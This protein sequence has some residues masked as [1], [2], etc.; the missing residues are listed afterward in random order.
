MLTLFPPPFPANKEPR[1]R[2]DPCLFGTNYL[3]ILTIDSYSLVRLQE[4]REKKI[5]SQW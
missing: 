2:T 5:S 4:T 1:E 3:Q